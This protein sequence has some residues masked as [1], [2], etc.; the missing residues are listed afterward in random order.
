MIAYVPYYIGL[1]TYFTTDGF[2]LQ[3][4]SDHDLPSYVGETSWHLIETFLARPQLFHGTQIPR[5]KNQPQS[6]LCLGRS[7]FYVLLPPQN[8]SRGGCRDTR[9]YGVPSVKLVQ[10]TRKA[11]C[12]QMVCPSRFLLSLAFFYHFAKSRCTSAPVP[13]AGTS[14]A[15]M[16]LHLPSSWASSVGGKRH[17]AKETGGEKLKQEIC[18]WNIPEVC[19][20]PRPLWVRIHNDGI[21]GWE[22]IK[23]NIFMGTLWGYKCYWNMGIWPQ[24]KTTI[25]GIQYVILY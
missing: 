2:W 18:Y 21:T 22:R 19:Q 14:R 20:A 24:V 16:L 8:W 5:A 13:A 15:E 1:S 12:L 10:G 9:G 4:P 6:M 7:T 25:K 3:N 11:L 17:T 23:N